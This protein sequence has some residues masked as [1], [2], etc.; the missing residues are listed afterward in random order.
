[1]L[2]GAG[3]SSIRSDGSTAEVT[4]HDD[5]RHH[6]V[7]ADHVLANVAPWV[8]RILLG[9]EPEPDTK[10]EAPSSRSTSCSI[11]CPSSGPAPTP[12]SPSPAPC[13]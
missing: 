12:R 7:T 8:L 1:M 5:T 13:T 10:P 2:T 6:T 3:V 4:W 11:D 9:E